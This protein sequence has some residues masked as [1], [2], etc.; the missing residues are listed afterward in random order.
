MLAAR[1]KIGNSIKWNAPDK[2]TSHSSEDA[3]PLKLCIQYNFASGFQYIILAVNKWWWKFIY[4]FKADLLAFLKVHYNFVSCPLLWA[5]CLGDRTIYM[6]T[7]IKHL[8]TE[9]WPRVHVALEYVILQWHE[10]WK[11]FCGLEIQNRIYADIWK[12]EENS[13]NINHLSTWY[14][15][16]LIAPNVKTRIKT[17]KQTTLLTTINRGISHYLI[18][19]LYFHFPQKYIQSL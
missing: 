14:F 5:F 3:P 13:K 15:G 10:K 8:P 4:S 12:R 11:T 18:L 2:I 6:L 19:L 17:P 9:G 7:L 1:R 16:E